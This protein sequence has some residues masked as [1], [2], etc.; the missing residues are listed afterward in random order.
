MTRRTIASEISKTGT[1]LHSG[2]AVAMT[3]SAAASGTGIVFRRSD[4]A[5]KEISAL[6]DRVIAQAPGGYYACTR[7]CDECRVRVWD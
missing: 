4:L 7:C 3:L 1:A 5:N 6:Y 2:V